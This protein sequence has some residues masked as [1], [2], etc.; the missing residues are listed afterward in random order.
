MTWPD[1]QPIATAPRDRAVLLY[2]P[3]DPGA[4][5]EEWIGVG[6]FELAEEERDVEG[7]WKA[8]SP[9]VSATG[10]THWLPLPE[11]PKRI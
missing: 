3:A 1:W 10:A 6:R 5:R 8:E 7:Y 11:A 2:A 4:G 9:L